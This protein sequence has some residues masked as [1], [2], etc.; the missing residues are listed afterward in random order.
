MTCKPTPDLCFPLLIG[1]ESAIASEK[2]MATPTVGHQSHTHICEHTISRQG[3]NGETPTG[4]AT[5]GKD[6][7]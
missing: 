3:P 5:T 4:F 6:P 2:L 1:S 7:L